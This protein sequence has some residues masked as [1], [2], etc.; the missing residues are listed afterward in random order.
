MKKNLDQIVSEATSLVHEEDREALKS[1]LDERRPSIKTERFPGYFEFDYMPYLFTIVDRETFYRYAALNWEAEPEEKEDRIVV[2][3]DMF[4]LDENLYVAKKDGCVYYDSNTANRRLSGSGIKVSDS[5]SDVWRR[6]LE[7]FPEARRVL[8]RAATVNDEKGDEEDD[9]GAELFHYFSNDRE[10]EV[11][12][13]YASLRKFGESYLEFGE[14]EITPENFYAR[15]AFKLT[16]PF[17]RVFFVS[18]S[19]A[20]VP[21]L[22]LEIGM[23]T[24]DE[25]TGPA[26]GI[27]YY[28]PAT[29]KVCRVDPGIDCALNGTIKARPSSKDVFDC[30][31]FRY[32]SFFLDEDRDRIDAAESYAQSLRKR[33]WDYFSGLTSEETASLLK[34]L[35]LDGKLSLFQR[36]FP[37]SF[38]V[39]SFSGGVV[40]ETLSVFL[41]S[42]REIDAK[43]K[44][45]PVSYNL[46]WD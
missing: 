41:D 40:A 39:V 12:E 44:A 18:E 32:E 10:D 19:D 33:V 28:D 45:N 15:S 30:S 43:A 7:K 35:G 3:E 16:F 4:H 13:I 5:L 1:Y 38:E 36:L 14:C 46:D 29:R 37:P 11:K 22:I 6:F 21:R 42:L 27:L 24:E 20:S 31:S 26:Q 8:E 17:S 25:D 2:A 34:D 9:E 23:E